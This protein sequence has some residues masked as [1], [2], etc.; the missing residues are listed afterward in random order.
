VPVLRILVADDQEV[1][2]KRICTI[3]SAHVEFEV[4]AEASNG[5]EA[6]AMTRALRPDLIVLDI[7][8]PLLN[9]LDA[10]RQIREFAPH[11][12]I[13][14]LSVHRSKQLMEEASKIGVLGYVVKEDAGNNLPRAIA[15]ALRKETSFPAEL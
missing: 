6:V 1:V 2:R 5:R 7:S 15:R 11:T 14:I 3:L 4:C 10:A 9:G 13:V 12:P 8:M